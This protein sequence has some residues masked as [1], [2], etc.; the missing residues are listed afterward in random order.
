LT[1]VMHYNKT[2]E[3]RTRRVQVF[4]NWRPKSLVLCFNLS[5]HPSGLNLEI[6]LWFHCCLVICFFN[7]S[8]MEQHSYDDNEF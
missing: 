3:S 8:K 1:G 5:I 7:P 4:F 6:G 2:Y